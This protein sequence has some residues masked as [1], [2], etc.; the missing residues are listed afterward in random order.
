MGAHKVSQMQ[1]CLAE[2]ARQQA[3]KVARS[4]CT[5]ALHMDARGPRLLVRYRLCTSSLK[6]VMGS[7]PPL[8]SPK[9]A[10]SIAETAAT[11]LRAFCS[12]NAKQ[13]RVRQMGLE[14]LPNT[15]VTAHAAGI[16]TAKQPG[17]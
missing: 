7:L 1:W 17:G 14:A 3:Q 4:A 13:P 6:V 11:A 2:A 16:S 10:V 15:A 5:I 8:E 9:D 12:S